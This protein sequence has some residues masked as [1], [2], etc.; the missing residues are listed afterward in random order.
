MKHFFNAEKFVK[1]KYNHLLTALIL[2][3]IF[4]PRL[5]IR[6]SQSSSPWIAIIFFVV[7]YSAL[8]ITIPKG[9]LFWAFVGIIALDLS[10][11]VILY[12]HPEDHILAGGL[13][14]F[15]TIVSISLY[16]A[17][18]YFLSLRLFRTRIVT[19]DTIKGGICAYMLIGFAWANIYGLMMDTKS[20]TLP[21]MIVNATETDPE[22]LREQMM[23]V[24]F[25]FTTLTTLGYGDIVPTTHFAAIVSD[26][27]A[28]IGQLFLTIFV[29]R[30]VGMYIAQEMHKEH[31]ELTP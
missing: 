2:L 26:A 24:H 9:K 25:S 6:D 15:N 22:I 21:F 31:R 12:Y 20:D 23:Y 28:I 7:L 4:S 29:A 30:L 18:S 1:N 14:K 5:E 17:T 10:L 19:P 8:R 27:E 16:C 13:E 3:F 11:N